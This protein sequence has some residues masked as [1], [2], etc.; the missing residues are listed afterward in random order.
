MYLR[1]YERLLKYF[2]VQYLYVDIV[3]SHLFESFL[4]QGIANG[5]F[6]SFHLQFG[7]FLPEKALYAHDDSA[8][9]T[10]VLSHVHAFLVIVLPY[11]S[12]V[13]V[14]YVTAHLTLF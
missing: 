9:D 7:G 6:E 3:Q 1:Q 4:W 5:V 10:D 2:S 8:I 11:Q 13:N 12:G 14:Q